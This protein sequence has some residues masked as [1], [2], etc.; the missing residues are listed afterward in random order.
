M[1]HLH[2]NLDKKVLPTRK[3]P[4]PASAS[5]GG[6]ADDLDAALFGVSGMINA[7]TLNY[8]SLKSF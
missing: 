6:V 2:E 5:G 8:I 7:H 3:T 4:L 1:S